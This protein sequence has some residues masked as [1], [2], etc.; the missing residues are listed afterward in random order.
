MANSI[1]VREYARLTSEKL[2]SNTLDQAQISET[3]FTWLCELDQTYR[4]SGSRLLEKNGQ[5]W[6]RLDSY[7]GVLESPCGQVIEILPKH[8]DEGDVEE[9]SRLLLR[10]LIASA[11][12]LP[13]REAEEAALSLYHTS[14]SEWVM[15]QFLLSLEHLL[16]KGIRFDYQRLE[17]EQ[18]Y[19]RGQ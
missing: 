19:L 16:M 14:L 5:Q 6:I 10:K 8:H 15:H 1:V 17:E 12:D 9:F 13:S 2:E 18:R 3:A 4:S 11:L 7:V